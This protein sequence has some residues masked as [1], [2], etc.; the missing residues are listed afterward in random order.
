MSR[1]PWIG[2]AFRNGPYE[3]SLFVN[4]Q[5]TMR[6]RRPSSSTTSTSTS[7]AS[8]QPYTCTRHLRPCPVP[9]A[10]HR[11]P[12]PSATATDP[13]RRPAPSSRLAVSHSGRSAPQ[14]TTPS[15]PAA[16]VSG[17]SSV[18]FQM[19]QMPY[20]LRLHGC[21]SPM[22]PRFHA[23]RH[24]S[25]MHPHLSSASPP[26][27]HRL[28]VDHLSSATPTSALLTPAS[29]CSCSLPTGPR[30][31]SGW[32]PVAP[33]RG[34]LHPLPRHFSDAR[35]SADGLLSR[36]L[37]AHPDSQSGTQLQLQP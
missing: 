19:P 18:P 29:F 17:P 10:P 20:A 33:R 26:R 30:P 24:P 11:R 14:M 5:T 13:R 36:A 25:P 1:R 9:P 8:S 15:S 12:T 34:A 6:A 21:T 35:A 7:T 4:Q 37:S 23:S 27:C 16:C 32:D 28:H 2:L 31:L 3:G 22:L